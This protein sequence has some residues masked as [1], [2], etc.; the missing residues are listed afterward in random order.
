MEF[1][2]DLFFK[3]DYTNLPFVFGRIAVF[4]LLS[5]AIIW[6]LWTILSKRMY[7]KNEKLPKEY[8]LKLAFMWSLIFY[9]VIFSIYLFF[10]FKRNGIDSFHWENPKFYLAISSHLISIIAS[11][12]IFIVT[13]FQLSTSIK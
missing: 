13:Q 11:I 12:I 8:K 10:F 5:M 2:I 3:T 1:L 7:V 9:Y 4:V 6:L